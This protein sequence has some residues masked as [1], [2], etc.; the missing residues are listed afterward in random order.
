LG[1]N[2]KG[3]WGLLSSGQPGLLCKEPNVHIYTDSGSV[4]GWIAS[5][6]FGVHYTPQSFVNL[7]NRIGFT[8][9]KTK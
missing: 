6:A 3:Y 5:A 7:L 1:N 8:Y 2:S 4:A 9:K